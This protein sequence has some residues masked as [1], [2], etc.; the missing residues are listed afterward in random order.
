MLRARK[1]TAAARKKNPRERRTR[2][3]SQESP[4]RKPQIPLSPLGITAWKSGTQT[5]AHSIVVSDRNSRKKTKKRESEIPADPRPLASANHHRRRQAA[6]ARTT[7]ARKPNPPKKPQARSVETTKPDAHQ[8]T[9]EITREQHATARTT[10]LQKGGQK[11]QRR[12]MRAATNKL[13]T[14]QPSAGAPR[15]WHSYS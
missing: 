7:F 10:I 4:P 1:H 6:E 5:R 13:R 14:G 8:P 11:P 9:D 3:E 15:H 2:A 12:R